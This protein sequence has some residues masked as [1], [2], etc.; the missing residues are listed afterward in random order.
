MSAPDALER[1]I[2]SGLVAEISAAVTK[3]ANGI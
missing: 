2:D 3:E 1:K